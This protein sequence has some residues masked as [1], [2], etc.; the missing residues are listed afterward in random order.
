MFLCHDSHD[1][2]YCDTMRI[3]SS[4]IYDFHFYQG[5]TSLTSISSH[6][7]FIYFCQ[8]IK[9]NFFLFY[10]LAAHIADTD[11]AP[12]VL[13]RFTILCYSR[14]KMNSKQFPNVQQIKYF[15]Y[16]TKMQNKMKIYSIVSANSRVNIRD[17][18]ATP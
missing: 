5:R 16:K 9:I 11:T 4:S 1:Q 14:Q 10:G 13:E 6:T 8:L 2:K 18:H 7:L 15:L 12:D 17:S 3:F